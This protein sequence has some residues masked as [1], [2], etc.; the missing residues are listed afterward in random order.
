MRSE[1]FVVGA[2]RSAVSHSCALR[3]AHGWGTHIF[4]CLRSETW[5]THSVAGPKMH[6]GSFQEYCASLRGRSDWRWELFSI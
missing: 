4:P 1:G 2:V 3:L 6:T 5:G